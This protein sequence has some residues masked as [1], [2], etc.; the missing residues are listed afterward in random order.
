MF[1]ASRKTN[2]V[3]NVYHPSAARTSPLRCVTED[4]P[5]ATRALFIM[6]ALAIFEDALLE[7]ARMV[8]DA[9][10]AAVEKIQARN[11]GHIGDDFYE[12]ATSNSAA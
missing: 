11:T 6:D 8:R 9:E 5:G 1:G 4:A 3:S 7:I 12:H 10:R 2:G